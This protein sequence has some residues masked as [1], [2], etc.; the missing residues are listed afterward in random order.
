M[1]VFPVSEAL[2][3]KFNCRK[4]KN[5]ALVCLRIW[6]CVTVVGGNW[7]SRVS[8]F[9]GGAHL[10]H[11][12]SD[13]I[14]ESLRQR[15]TSPEKFENA[16]VNFLPEFSQP[17][18][19]SGS[20]AGGGD[21]KS[22]RATLLSLYQTSHLSSFCTRPHSSLVARPLYSIVPTNQK[23]RAGQRFSQTQIQNDRWLLRLR[24]LRR[25]GDGN[26]WCVLE[27]NL[28][29]FSNSSGIVWLYGALCILV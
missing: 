22:G 9:G 27:W 14:S 3:F 29:R 23:P 16:H 19:S 11:S 28:C 1:P 15:P 20:G 26:I 25:S 13:S 18:P 24:F 2:L 6:M 21:Q 7:K 5:K 17:F 12:Y 8:S 4:I 10:P